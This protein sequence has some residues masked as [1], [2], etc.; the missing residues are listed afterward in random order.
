MKKSKVKGEIPLGKNLLRTSRKQKQIMRKFRNVCWILHKNGMGPPERHNIFV[1]CLN[2][3]QESI[4]KKSVA[5]LK[6][7]E[8]FIDRVIEDYPDWLEGKKI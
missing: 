7:Q 1:E 4:N 2:K 8:L 5:Q 3:A 6:A